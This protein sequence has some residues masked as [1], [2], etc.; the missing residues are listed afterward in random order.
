MFGNWLEFPPLN[1][2][3]DEADDLEDDDL[4]DE[5]EAIDEEPAVAAPPP[6]KKKKASAKAGRTPLKKKR[7]PPPSTCNIATP[8]YPLLAL[9]LR[10]S[11]YSPATRGSV[12]N[13]CWDMDQCLAGWYSPRDR[14]TPRRERLALGEGPVA[15]PE[16]LPAFTATLRRTASTSS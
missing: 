7:K 12:S 5:D 15:R 16:R 8:S 3:Q 10:R 2:L 1:A 6:P 4:E 9:R 14:P 11:L 13:S